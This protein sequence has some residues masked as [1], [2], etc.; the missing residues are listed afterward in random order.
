MNFRQLEAFHNVMISGSTVRAA[1]LMHVTQ[2][3]ISR[4]IAELESAVGF[5]LFDRTRARLV[6]TAEGQRF[7]REVAASFSGLD[8]LKSSAAA[9]RDYGTGNL[10]IGSLFA[11]GNGVVARAM[12]AFHRDN[13][14]VRMSLRIR[15]SAEVRNDVADGNFDIGVA[16]DEIDR[17]GVDTELLIERDGVI[18]MAPDHP[19]ARRRTLGPKDV[20]R[21]PLIGLSPEDRA[22]RRLEAVLDAAGVCPD[23]VIETPAASTACALALTGSTIAFV[24]PLAVD[25]FVERGLVLRPF[26]PAVLFRAFLVFPVHTQRPVL[27]REFTEALFRFASAPP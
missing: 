14:K 23:Y 13:P 6:P 16:A 26:A 10:A 25:G 17:S 22:R 12:S 20:A 8:R 24:N 9:I 21:Y 5:A 18:A 11:L 4:N 3:A 2:P 1:E 15:S 19:L 27:V 7:F